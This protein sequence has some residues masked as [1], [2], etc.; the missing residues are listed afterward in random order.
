MSVSSEQ[1][2]TRQHR[3]PVCGGADGDPRGQEQRCHGFTS[4]EGDWVHCSREELAG[5]IDANRAGLYAHKMHGPCKCGTTHGED[6]RPRNEPEAVY[7]YLDE[8]G[9]LLFEVVRFP[10]KQ[11]R[12]RKP[13]GGGGHEWKLN[14]VRRV[15]YHLL[16]LVEDD[17]ERP[18]YVVEG[19]KDADTLDKCG[20]LS[21]TNPGGAGKWHIVADVA[22]TALQGRDVV[23]VADRDEVGRRHAEEVRASLASVARSICVVE[24]PA[25]H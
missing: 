9:D 2:H 3:C 4:A 12:Q 19:E 23:V 18:V 25:P 21:T 24:P 5:A 20:H 17:G 15:P 1:R 8:H 6:Y 22:R 11:F 10:G 7:P 13:D 14:G 16:E